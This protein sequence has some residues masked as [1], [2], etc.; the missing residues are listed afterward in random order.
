MRRTYLKKYQLDDGSGSAQGTFGTLVQRK[1]VECFDA[2]CQVLFLLD[3]DRGSIWAVAGV[4]RHG[5]SPVVRTQGQ[6]RV[7]ESHGAQ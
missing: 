2:Y 6:S 7:V 1:L 3:E 5:G 4:Y